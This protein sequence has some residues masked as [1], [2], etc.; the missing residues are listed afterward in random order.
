MKNYFLII[1]TTL[2]YSCGTDLDGEKNYNYSIINN[3]GVKVELIPTFNGIKSLEKKVDLE[4]GA[5]FN[6]KHTDYPIYTSPLSIPSMFNDFGGQGALTQ[7]EI[8]FNNSKKI[9]YSKCPDLIC[10]NVRNIFHFKNSENLT[11][12]YTITPEDYQNAVDCGGNCN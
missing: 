11:E 6:K 3:S 4:N 12:I 5:V 8:T 2:I 1:L 9:I 10:T 7:L